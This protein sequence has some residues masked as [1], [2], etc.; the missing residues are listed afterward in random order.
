LGLAS[1][2]RRVSIAAALILIAS[3]AA[4]P[5]VSTVSAAAPPRHGGGGRPGGA[6]G[7]ART[8]VRAKVTA[9][10]PATGRIEITGAG[11]TLAAEFPAAVVAETKPGDVVFV[12]LDLIDTRLA[13]VRGS[14]VAVDQAKGTAVVSTPGGTL[15]LNPS[16]AALAAMKPGDDVLLKLNLVDIGN[17]DAPPKPRALL[18][19]PFDQP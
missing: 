15:T 4:M 13:T 16:G 3:A 6:Q 5:A 17:T 10:D 2:V 19:T 18:D 8:L 7:D 9:V 11:L 14:V 12:T 1:L